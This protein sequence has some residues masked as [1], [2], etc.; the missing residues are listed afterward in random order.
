MWADP[1][2]GRASSGLAQI[3]QHFPQ[4]AQSAFPS[5]PNKRQ[6]CL[7]HSTITSACPPAQASPHPASS[8]PSLPE[9][10]LLNDS[11]KAMLVFRKGTLSHPRGRQYPLVAALS[12][13]GGWFNFL[14]AHSE[15]FEDILLVHLPHCI[16]N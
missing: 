5:P 11:L 14:T 8:T 4:P 9:G 10:V 16:H 6:C 2:H 13:F 15:T 12:A 1:A 7:V 3:L